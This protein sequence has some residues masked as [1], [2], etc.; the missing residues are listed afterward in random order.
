MRIGCSGKKGQVCCGCVGGMP[1]LLL[2]QIQGMRE[3]GGVKSGGV[4]TFIVRDSGQKGETFVSFF[5]LLIY[6]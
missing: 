2:Q 4:H 1:L 3:E 6:D 5:E